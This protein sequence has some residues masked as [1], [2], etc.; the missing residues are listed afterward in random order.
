M[1]S[2]SACLCLAAGTVMLLAQST[3]AFSFS[4]TVAGPCTITTTYAGAS[5]P[6]LCP[7]PNSQRAKCQASAMMEPDGAPI[8]GTGTIS[9][10][11]LVPVKV[12]YTGTECT[13]AALHTNVTVFMNSGFLQ[14]VMSTTTLE[15]GTFVVDQAIGLGASN[16]ITGFYRANGLGP[17]DPNCEFTYTVT[18]GACLLSDVPAGGGGGQNGSPSAS[19]LLRASAAAMLGSVLA[20][21]AS[22]AVLF[23]Y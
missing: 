14:C 13:A 10:P 2:T 21:A 22:F 7:D 3:Q 1:R 23:V 15:N 4:G 12:T 17:N 9:D 5:N 8:V 11:T 19:N 20:A 6:A 18:S 16:G